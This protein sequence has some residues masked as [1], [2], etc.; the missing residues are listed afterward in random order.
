MLI[1][2]KALVLACSAIG[3]GLAEQGIAVRTGLHCAPAA[4]RTAGTLKTGTV[5]VSVSDFNTTGEIS[6]FLDAMGRLLV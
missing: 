2:S 6:A 4:H 3:A 1:E 5:R